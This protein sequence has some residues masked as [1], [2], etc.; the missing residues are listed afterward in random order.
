M[1]TVK[2]NNKKYEIPQLGFGEYA[3]IEEQGFSLLEAFRKN[4][5]ML[6]AMGFVCVVVGTDRDGAEELIQ[7]H[8]LGG[9]NVLDIYTTFV[10]AVSNSGFFKKMLGIK[11][12]PA[13]KTTK[14]TTTEA[15]TE[16]TN[17]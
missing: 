9:G 10:E 16:D 1:S 6:L 11:E 7:Q 12:E 17:E 3:K 2:I 15:T 5:S 4:Q 13:K 8:V 14:Q